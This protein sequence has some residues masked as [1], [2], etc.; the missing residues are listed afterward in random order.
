MTEVALG[1]A[2]LTALMLELWRRYSARRRV[3]ANLW[4]W[5]VDEVR[6]HVVGD[7]E[8]PAAALL[9]VAL[10]GPAALRRAATAALQQWNV[11]GDPQRSLT[12]LAQRLADPE[13]DR[14]CEAVANCLHYDG[15]VERLLTRL[16][17]VAVEHGAQSRQLRRAAAGGSVARW[18]L[19]A[20]V[21]LALAGQ[22]DA[23]ASR[24]AVATAVVTWSLAGLALQV[25]QP[26]RVFGRST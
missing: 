16:H 6:T 19:L 26:P 22:L 23:D 10:H 14:V 12:I 15:D 8:P 24:W 13:A 25:P 7:D 11:D 4:P 20:P 1:G 17:D 18:L 3:A 9:G 2:V 21:A 5:L